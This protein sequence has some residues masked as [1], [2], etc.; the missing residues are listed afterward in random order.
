MST[1]TR[2]AL[3]DFIPVLF[4]FFQQHEQLMEALHSEDLN[5]H[6]PAHVAVLYSQRKSLQILTGVDENVYA[7]RNSKTGQILIHCAVDSCNPYIVQDILSVRP[8]SLFD[9][10]DDGK[11][12][13]HYAAALRESFLLDFLLSRGA[14]ILETDNNKSKLLHEAAQAGSISNVELLAVD[15]VTLLHATDMEERTP[16]HVACAKGFQNIVSFLLENGADQ[17]ARST[18]GKNCLEVAI[19]HKQEYVVNELLMSIY[20]KGLICDWKNGA[21]KCF[22]Y[23]AEK[24]PNQAKLLLDRCVVT[25]DHKRHSLDYNVTYLYVQLLALRVFNTCLFRR[26]D[27]NISRMLKVLRRS[28]LH[29]VCICSNVDAWEYLSQFFDT[30]S[31]LVKKGNLILKRKNIRRH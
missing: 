9:K 10:D 7:L 1:T 4:P 15:E 29:G 31:G 18:G 5:G 28:L 14:N 6:T 21:M 3:I 22:A 24:M 13:Q 30:H 27:I 26:T 12:P 19:I 25:S 11:A 2:I 17:Q 20:W 16:L 23:L 8:E